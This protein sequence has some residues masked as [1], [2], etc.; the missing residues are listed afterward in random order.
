MVSEW[1]I[2]HGV[3]FN[4][5]TYDLFFTSSKEELLPIGPNES[6]GSSSRDRKSEGNGKVHDNTFGIFN[7]S[8]SRNEKDV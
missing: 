6:S 4:Y 5:L 7:F 1:S 8:R 3:V 2:E